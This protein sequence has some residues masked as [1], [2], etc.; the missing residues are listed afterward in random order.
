LRV[1]QT[2]T[3]A[4]EACHDFRTKQAAQCSGGPYKRL[5]K[6]EASATNARRAIIS[7][8]RRLPGLSPKGAI[9]HSPD[10]RPIG[11][12]LTPR[13][14]VMLVRMTACA[15]PEGRRRVAQGVRRREKIG[16]RQKYARAVILSEAKNLALSSV[17]ISQFHRQSE[18]LRFAQDD[19][20][21]L[22]MTG[23]LIFSQLQS[24]GLEQGTDASPVR[25]GRN[26]DAPRDSCSVV[27]LWVIDKRHRLT[28]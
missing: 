25:G 13:G 14:V 15:G 9:Y 22:R 19:S 3:M 1:S 8:A 6:L 27:V 7:L 4:L 2:A 5:L 21:G 20:E 11:A 28:T 10:Q 16:E 17:A 26:K 24:R 12:N 23:W 18:I